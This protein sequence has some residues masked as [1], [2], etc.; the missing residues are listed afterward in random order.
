M[1]NQLIACYARGKEAAELSVILGEAALSDLDK[2][3]LKFSQAFEEKYILQ[4]EDEDRTIEQT[5]DLGWELLRQVPRTEMKRVREE[6]LERY[7]DKVE[8]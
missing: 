3:Y 4:G 1:F 5:L 8:G 6:H 7:Y 2:I